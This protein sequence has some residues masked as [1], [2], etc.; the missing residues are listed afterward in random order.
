MKVVDITVNGRVFQ[1]ACDDGQ[2]KHLIDLA[3]QI[4]K[5]VEDL[6]SKMGQVGDARLILMAGL[7]VAD[8]LSESL[9]V[10]DELDNKLNIVKKEQEKNI[11]KI[12]ENAASR[13]T[14]IAA[15]V[16]KA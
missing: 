9:E 13:I 11:E 16:E 12:Y 1:V 5:K 7:L 10:I 6:A 2:E 15:L 14:N 8:E 4:D 3:S